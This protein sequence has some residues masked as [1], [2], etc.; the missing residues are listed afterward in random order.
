MITRS[1]AN[2]PAPALYFYSLEYDSFQNFATFLYVTIEGTSIFHE[3]HKWSYTWQWRHNE[4]VGVSNHQPHDC[5][6]N[7]LFTRRSKKISKLRVIDL[8]VGNSPVMGIH[9]WPL[10]SPHKGPVTRKML[11]LDDVIMIFAMLEILWKRSSVPWWNVT[12]NW[13][14]ANGKW[15][16]HSSVIVIKLIRVGNLCTKLGLTS[17]MWGVFCDD[18]E[19]MQPTDSV[20]YCARGL[21]FGMFNLGSLPTSVIHVFP[22][23]FNGIMGFMRVIIDK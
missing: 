10:N 7:R 5:F 6:L 4:L 3:M 14:A 11:P 21:P 15:G 2:K 8:C 13:I 20:L 18:L 1:S 19:N 23:Y 12:S 9:Q 22:D 17:Q 16:I